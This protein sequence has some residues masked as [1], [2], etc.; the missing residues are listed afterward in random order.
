MGQ[1]PDRHGIPGQTRA[2]RCHAAFLSSTFVM[3]LAASMGG[4]LVSRLLK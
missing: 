2:C 1:P 3:V 4:T